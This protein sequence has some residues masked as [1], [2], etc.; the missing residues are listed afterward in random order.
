MRYRLVY[1]F[2]I[3]SLIS[4]G[5]VCAHGHR[6]P[7]SGYGHGRPG[8]GHTVYRE[9]YS[10]RGYRQEGY[11]E[12][13]ASGGYGGPGVR[14]AMFNHHSECLVGGRAGWIINHRMILGVAGYGL[15]T[16]TLQSVVGGRTRTLGLGYGGVDLGYVFM[17]RA[18][19]HVSFQVLIGAGGV[20]YDY[21]T[22]Q[23]TASGDPIWS[24]ESSSFFV[25]EPMFYLELNLSPWV[26]LCAG[27]GYRW[28]Q[29]VDASRVGLDSRAL[30]GA[31][32]EV[33]LKFG[34]F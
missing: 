20:G 24:T 29:G 15:T 3:F 32:E 19:M 28:V 7:R 22:G 23:V 25:T 13:F 17:P 33:L 31:N 4:P 12:P 30:S 34:F 26:R 8:Y 2:I 11:Y 21:R 27:T 9:G 5:L 6:H 10:D 16:N 18:P 1:G 14:M